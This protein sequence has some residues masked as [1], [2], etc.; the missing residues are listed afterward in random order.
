[1]LH[2]AM[3]YNETAIF[4]LYFKLIHSDDDL[5]IKW[6]YYSFIIINVVYC[7]GRVEKQI[8]LHV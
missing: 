2:S 8:E 4:P 3:C 5:E 6:K 7:V 1:M